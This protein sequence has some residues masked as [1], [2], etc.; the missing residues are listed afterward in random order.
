MA[1]LY[2]TATPV[3]GPLEHY[4]FSGPGLLPNGVIDISDLVIVARNFGR[5]GTTDGTPPPGTDI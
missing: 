4:D 1:G 3:T 2:G 5:S